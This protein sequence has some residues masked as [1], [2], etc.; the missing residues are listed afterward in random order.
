MP[1]KSVVAQ[2]TPFHTPELVPPI[3]MTTQGRVP[4]V[5]DTLMAK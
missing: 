1:R 4:T 3:C 5:F 2:S